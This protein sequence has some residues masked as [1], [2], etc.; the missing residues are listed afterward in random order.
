MRGS[1]GVSIYF[2]IV[3]PSPKYAELPFAKDSGWHG[4]LNEVAGLFPEIEHSHE[5]EVAD[6]A[7]GFDSGVRSNGGC[8]GLKACAGVPGKFG[9]R[10]VQIVPPIRRRECA[11]RK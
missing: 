11:S 3:E 8:E 7:G 2:P 10:M 5:E 1:N 6:G 9:Q 4:F